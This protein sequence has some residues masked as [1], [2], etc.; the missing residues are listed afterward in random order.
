MRNADTRPA[1]GKGRSIFAA[2]VFRLGIF[3]GPFKSDLP[4]NFRTMPA[5]RKNS[6][7][8]TL[9]YTLRI[10]VYD[11]FPTGAFVALESFLVFPAVRLARPSKLRPIN[12]A[13]G[14]FGCCMVLFKREE[15]IW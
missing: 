9:C 12:K 10:S 15:S 8:H 5:F 6:Y 3:R 4:Y 11:G 14:R 7:F 1:P 2:A 13:M